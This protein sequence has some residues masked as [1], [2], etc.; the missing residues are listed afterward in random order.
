MARKVW[1]FFCSVKLTIVLFVLILIPSTIGTIIQQNAPD[2]TKYVEIYGPAWDGVFRF[3]GFYDIYHD[4]RFI[5]LLVLLGL[6]TF[7]CTLNRLK[8][9]WRMLG[10]MMTHF[11]LLLI[12]TGGLIGA[13][14]GVKGFMVIH[15]GE[16]TDEMSIGQVSH[17]V[18]TLP[19]EVKLV[20][21]ILDTHEEPAEELIVFDVKAKRESKY[22]IEQGKSYPLPQPGWVKPVSLLGLNFNPTGTVEITTVFPHATMVTSLTEGP[23]K[24]GIAAVEFRILGNN[25]EE[26]AFAVSQMQHPYVFAPAKIGVGYAKIASA[27]TVDEQIRKAAATFAQATNRLEVTVPEKTA[28]TVYSA[29][30]GSKFEVAGTDYSIEVLRYVPDF[31]IDTTTRQVTSR[32]QFPNNPAIQ[33][34]VTGPA[35]AKEQWIFSKFPAVHTAGDIPLQLKFLRNESMAGIEDYVLVLSPADG[36]PVF[37][38]IAEGKPAKTAKLEPGKPFEIGDT[39]Y[40]I[41][42]DKFFENANMKP[43]MVNR[44]DGPGHPAIEITLDHGGSPKS[45]YLWAGNPTDVNGYRMMY[46]QEERIRDFYSILQIIDGGKMVA[47]KKIEVNDPLRYGGYSFYQ[48]SYDSEAL[49]WSGLQVKKDPGV[50]LVYAGFSFQILGMIVI[51]YINPLVRKAR[52]SQA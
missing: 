23:E 15:E 31:V 48:S 8:L 20:D 17:G 4:L 39:G 49:R 18:E 38:H 33:V 26:S 1:K 27:N 5:I 22:K 51:F 28:P 36:D 3:L 25:V 44:T 19:F 10:M 50:P 24:T 37:A 40:R 13:I 34:R 2:P 12:L 9:Q 30:V 46:H 43:E 29:D 35:G 42:A 16:T 41:V 11:G 6:N 45:H 47:E 21:F 52:K 32:S 7:A 14:A